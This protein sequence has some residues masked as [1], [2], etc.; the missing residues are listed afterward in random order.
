MRASSAKLNWEE[1]GKISWN[2][3]KNSVTNRFFPPSV[4]CKKGWE[5]LQNYVYG[6]WFANCACMLCGLCICVC[7]C[8]VVY[9][10]LHFACEHS[11]KLGA[12]Q[13]ICK[14]LER[15]EKREK[16]KVGGHLLVHVQHSVTFVRA[17]SVYSVVC[18]QVYDLCVWWMCVCFVCV[19]CCVCA[20]EHIPSDSSEFA[21]VSFSSRNASTAST[22]STKHNTS[23]DTTC[24]CVRVWM[25]P[26]WVFISE[27]TLCAYES[28]HECRNMGTTPRWHNYVH[29][30]GVSEWASTHIHGNLPFSC[31]SCCI[32]LKRACVSLYVDIDVSPLNNSLVRS[33]EEVCANRVPSCAWFSMY[34]R[35]CEHEFE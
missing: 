13:V 32:L 30:G 12:Q 19:T 17:F 27:K 23:D 4:S 5:F 9:L 24:V 14:Q 7:V 26:V 20:W 25:C 28:A 29:V 18:V 3:T 10:W 11:H 31:C 22:N 8:P 33:A 15:W 35:V 2:F 34:V 16:R 6:L 21:S 1:F